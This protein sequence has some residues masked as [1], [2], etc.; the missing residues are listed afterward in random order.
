MNVIAMHPSLHVELIKLVP[1]PAML[2][3][4]RKAGQVEAGAMLD[5]LIISQGT[6]DPVF[7]VN[8]RGEQLIYLYDE[9]LGLFPFARMERANME[10][11]AYLSSDMKGFRAVNL[12]RQEELAAYSEEWAKQLSAI[13]FGVEGV[14]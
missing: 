6:S 1:S 8:Y 2:K 12:G 13:F 7:V 9:T 4:I 11:S 5:G 10:R 3:F 14:G